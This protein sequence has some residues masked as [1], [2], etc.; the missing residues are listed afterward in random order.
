MNTEILIVDDVPNNLNLSGVMRQ[1]HPKS[2]LG[3]RC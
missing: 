3:V 1:D 2:V